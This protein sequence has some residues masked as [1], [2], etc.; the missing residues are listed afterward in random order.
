MYEICTNVHPIY[1][2]RSLN[3]VHRLITFKSHFLNKIFQ[4]FLADISCE[5]WAIMNHR[6]ISLRFNNVFQQS[7]DEVIHSCH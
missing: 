1:A 4:I 5:I 7:G 2:N 6:I 3:M